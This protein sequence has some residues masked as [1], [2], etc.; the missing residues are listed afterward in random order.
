MPTRRASSACVAF[1]PLGKRQPDFATAMQLTNFASF[2]DT[3]RNMYRFEQT[4]EDILDC[5][6]E[7]LYSRLLTG[8]LGQLT[9][10]FDA[11]PNILGVLFAYALG[12]AAAPT[13]SGPYTH[14][15]TELP[16]GVYQPP[17]FSLV[18]GFRGGGTPLLL[19]GCVVNSLVVRAEARGRV[20][21]SV[22]IRFAE[23]VPATGYALP[24]CINTVPLR[25]SDC[26]LMVGAQDLTNRLRRFEF[27]YNNQLLT[28]D[29]PFTAASSL[30]TRLERA[31]RRERRLQ[32]AVLGDDSDQ[33]FTDALAGTSAQISLRLGQSEYVEFQLG[34][35]LLELDGGGLQKDGEANET[36]I[37]INALPAVV[38]ATTPVVVR[39]VNNQSDA[40]LQVG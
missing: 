31:D 28:R 5:S 4:R 24:A 18:H 6:T 1:S 20:Q 8:Q 7:E 12:V 34:N 35:A 29:H 36:V 13:G 37:R 25:I 3:A 27:S 9:M 23:A 16:V 22:E 21:G 15:I 39:A 26:T 2:P 17:P 14:E 10:D 38:A 11:S 19:R 40:Y 30:P 33:L 32:F